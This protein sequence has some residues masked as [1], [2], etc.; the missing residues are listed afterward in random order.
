VTFQLTDIPRI[1][2]EL[3]LLVVAVLVLG[4]DILERWSG[5]PEEQAQRGRAAGELTV[6]MLGLVF[7]VALVQSKYLFTIGEPLQGGGLSA[8]VNLF[9]N[10]GRNLQAGGPGGEP[11]L[12]AFTTDNLTMISRLVF[13]GA[14]FLTTLL[15]LDYRPSGNPGEFYALILFATAGMSLMAAAS[16]LIMAYISLELSS[17]SL[18][19]LA[20]YFRSERTSAEAGIKYFLFGALSSGILLYGM[21]LAY[22]AAAAANRGSG[23]SGRS[24][25]RWASR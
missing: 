11:I 1:L 25:R 14:A 19:I 21:S 6:S 23:C 7:V 2:P 16:E 18:Y 24:R 10:L 15:A 13:I 20:G 5:D 4:S 12:G 8:V 9:I 22:G 3:M 17:I